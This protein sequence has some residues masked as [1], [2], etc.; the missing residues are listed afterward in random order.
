MCIR[1]SNNMLGSMS[2]TINNIK[3]EAEANSDSLDSNGVKKSFSE[4]DV[5]EGTW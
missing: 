2:E 3:H 5:E 1:D 4:Y